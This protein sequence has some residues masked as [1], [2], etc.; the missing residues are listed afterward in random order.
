MAGKE[1]TVYCAFVIVCSF[2][3]EPLRQFLLKVACFAYDGVE[4]SCLGCIMSFNIAKVVNSGKMSFEYIVPTSNT[5]FSYCLP[6][7]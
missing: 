1:I 5:V 4:G 7:N 6:C 2:Y 3:T